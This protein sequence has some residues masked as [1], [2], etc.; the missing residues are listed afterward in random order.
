MSNDMFSRKKVLQIF[1]QAQ[2]KEANHGDRR[3]PGRNQ[4]PRQLQGQQYSQSG[5]NAW[6]MTNART[7]LTKRM[8]RHHADNTS[9]EPMETA[10]QA[11]ACDALSILQLHQTSHRLSGRPSGK[12]LTVRQS[13]YLSNHPSVCPTATAHAQIAQIAKTRIL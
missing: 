3:M 13:N 11:F 1:S 4:S 12:H 7:S 6:T 10:G 5:K 9:K 2:K 8:H